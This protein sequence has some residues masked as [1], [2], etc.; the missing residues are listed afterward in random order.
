MSIGN[1]PAYPHVEH[2]TGGYRHLNPGMTYRQWLIG[3]IA[4][5]V[6]VEAKSE[7]WIKNQVIAVAD[8]IVAALDAEQK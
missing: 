1:K 4:S 5:G 8:A 3:Q 7:T 2:G 6:S